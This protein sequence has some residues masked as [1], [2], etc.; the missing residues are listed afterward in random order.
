MWRFSVKAALRQS[1]HSTAV[2]TCS[3]QLF[4]CVVVC[5]QR[6]C[7]KLMAMDQLPDALQRH[8]RTWLGFTGMPT[9]VTTVE[10]SQ[11]LLSWDLG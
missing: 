3:L 2:Q 11:D 5:V 9:V 4:Q 8:M 10:H 1:V 7:C 6:L